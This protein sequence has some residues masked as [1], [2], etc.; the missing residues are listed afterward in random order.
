ML[1]CSVA[2]G[3]EIDKVLKKDGKVL[4]VQDGKTGPL[5]QNVSFASDVKVT[6]NGF[7][8]IANGKEREL[9]EGQILTKDGLL[10]NADGSVSP[11]IDH[12][13][14]RNGRVYVVNNGQ[15]APLV[16]NMVLPNGSVVSTDGTLRMPGGRMVRLLDG[17]V[18]KLDGSPLGAKDT[19]SLMDGKVV[20]QKDGGLIKL[21]PS[22]RITMNDGTQVYGNGTV[23]SRD[24]RAVA[25]KEGETITLEGPVLSA[26]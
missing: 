24:G 16:Q 2:A 21:A 4:M 17:H 6:T 8:T 23:I 7:I 26:R 3:A 12:I 1:V 20:I 15:A 25:V 22:Q 14:M 9:K 18:L 11:V 13:T 5:N 10:Y 19:V